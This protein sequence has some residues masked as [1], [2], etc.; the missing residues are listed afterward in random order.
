MKLLRIFSLSMIILSPVLATIE[1]TAQIGGDLTQG[2]G[3]AIGDG[4]ASP[5]TGETI[6]SGLDQPIIAASAPA[7]AATDVVGLTPKDPNAIADKKKGGIPKTNVGREKKTPA[8]ADAAK[9]PGPPARTVVQV[10]TASSSQVIANPS[11]PPGQNCASITTGITHVSTVVGGKTSAYT[12]YCSMTE[13]RTMIVS[14]D[15]QGHS[16]TTQVRPTAAR[17]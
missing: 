13:T 5:S 8:K 1:R 7:A 2:I 9:K 6:K 17:A 4:V 16:S 12:A 11:C 14:T 3:G 10:V 15:A